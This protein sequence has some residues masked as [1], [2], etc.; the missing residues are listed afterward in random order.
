MDR[1][2]FFKMKD[3]QKTLNLVYLSIDRLMEF[4]SGSSPV[5][6]V[7]SESTKQ[8]GST[9]VDIL[10]YFATTMYYVLDGFC[11]RYM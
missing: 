9:L 6:R 7:V 2:F 11:L 4:Q 5:D 10:I 8:F 3:C 1:Y